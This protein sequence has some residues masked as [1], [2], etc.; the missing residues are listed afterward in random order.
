MA[1]FLCEQIDRNAIH[2]LDYQ[3]EDFVVS[4]L[5]I[6]HQVVFEVV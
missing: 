5:E 6:N 2:G 1:D 3:R 4:F